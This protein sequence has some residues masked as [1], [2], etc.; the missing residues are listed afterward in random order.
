MTPSI[1]TRKLIDTF[2]FFNEIEMLKARLEYLGPVVDHFVICEANIDFAGNKKKIILN[3]EI[4]KSLPFSEKIIFYKKEINFNS[5]LWSIKKI[6]YYKKNV[7]LLWKLQDSQRNAL[8]EPLKEFDENSLIIFSDLD[9]IP[10]KN[11]IEFFIKNYRSFQNNNQN[12]CIYSCKQIFFYYDLKHYATDDIFYGSV[13]TDLKN[14]RFYLPHKIKSNKNNFKH[15]MDGGWHFS[16]FMTAEK[17][18]EKI[19]AISDVENLSIYKSLDI[20]EIK[21]KILG[22]KDLYDRKLQLSADGIKYVPNDLVQI[23]KK[24]FPNCI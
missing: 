9:E 10:S 16:Y 23:L 12:S 3:E 6:R 17:I 18:R 24:H 8:L 22:N 13:M 1:K 2:L 11:A 19:L 21:E 5:V 15:I 4:I 7:R 20:E 14:F